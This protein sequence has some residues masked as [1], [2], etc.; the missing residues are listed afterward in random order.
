MSLFLVAEAGVNHNG[1][2]DL[3]KRLVDIA[4]DA[5]ADAVKFQTFNSAALVVP[6]APLAD[7]QMKSSNAGGSQYEMLKGLELGAEAHQVLAAQCR[8]R[9]AAVHVHAI[10]RGKCQLLDD[11]GVPVFKTPSPEITNLPLLAHIAAKGKPMIVSTGT[12]ISGRSRQ[13]STP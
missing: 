10:R 3:A 13:Q 2:L 8:R 4:A 7:Y 11:L 6:D 12:A 9:G 5:G 1:E